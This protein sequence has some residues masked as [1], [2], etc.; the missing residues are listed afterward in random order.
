MGSA[1]SV[2]TIGMIESIS[3]NDGARGHDIA[4]ECAPGAVKGA[5]VEKMRR[6]SKAESNCHPSPAN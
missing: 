6:D 3:P 5:E 1:V 4:L 2:F